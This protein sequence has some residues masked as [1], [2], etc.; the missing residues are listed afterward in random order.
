[1][2]IETLQHYGILAAGGNT[3]VHRNEL[4]SSAKFDP[5]KP[6]AAVPVGVAAIETQ[7]DALLC[8]IRGNLLTGLQQGIRATGIGGG[9]N[10]RVDVIDN[11]IEGAPEL[12]AAALSGQLMAGGGSPIVKLLAMLEGFS[13]IAISDLSHCRIADNEIRT[14]VCGVAAVATLG[15]SIVANRVSASLAG[16]MLLA[17][18]E[19][20]V[21]DNIVDAALVHAPSA[22]TVGIGLFLVGRSVVARNAVSRCVEGILSVLCTAVR[23]QD[24]D[25]YETEVGIGSLIDVDLEVRGNNIEDA[26]LIGISVIFSLHELTLA[27]DR[28]LR[29]GYRPAGGF[30]PNPA[31]GIEILL[32]ISLV[33]VEA[34]HV[35]DTGE[36]ANPGDPVFTAPRHGIVV[37][38]AIGAR[39]RGCEVASKPLVDTNGNVIGVNALS[40][41]VQLWTLPPA[42]IQLLLKPVGRSMIPFADATDN[43]IEQSGL[44]LVEIFAHDEIMFA[45][46]RC[47]NFDGGSASTVVLAGV[48]ATVT[49]NR[50]RALGKA[51]SLTVFFSMALSAVG[52]MTTA[53]AAIVPTAVGAVQTPAPYPSFNAT[54]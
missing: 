2:N 31:I 26:S 51:P 25:V 4:R 20:E 44:L 48:H 24:N 43:V 13:A 19:G 35:I 1:M 27:H 42:V 5:N 6:L 45:T 47:I 34:C 22:P 39:V 40:R 28:T 14:S 10:H 46:N 3:L 41:A 7:T 32:S 54:A 36:S 49:G 12:L 15:T 9:A 30:S 38:W 18:V 17:A 29:C 53:G 52:N 8:S 33:T 37:R 23:V 50:I 21:G 11:R 16:I